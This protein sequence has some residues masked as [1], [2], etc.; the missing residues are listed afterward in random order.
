MDL[1]EARGVLSNVERLEGKSR[2]AAMHKD[3][4]RGKL[5]VSVLGY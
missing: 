3:R 4:K 5:A 2:D 1:K